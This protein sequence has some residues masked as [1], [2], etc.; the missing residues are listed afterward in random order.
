MAVSVQ[1][2]RPRLSVVKDSPET[3]TIP[4]HI[5]VETLAEKLNQA[6]RGVEIDAPAED[7]FA[8]VSAIAYLAGLEAGRAEVA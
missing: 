7:F 2:S 5:E 3:V 6:L 8:A 1:G 4:T